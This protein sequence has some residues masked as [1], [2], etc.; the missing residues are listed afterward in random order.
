MD[1]LLKAINKTNVTIYKHHCNFH[2]KKT[3]LVNSKSP[4]RR[5]TVTDLTLHLM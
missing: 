3:I 4:I 2:S 5:I 1:S